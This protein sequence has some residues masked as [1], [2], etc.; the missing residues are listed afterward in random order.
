MSNDNSQQ[1]IFWKC[2]IQQQRESQKDPREVWRAEDEQ[3]KEREADRGV[4]AGPDVDQR[5]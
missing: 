4:S 5:E 1:I 3:A 2:V